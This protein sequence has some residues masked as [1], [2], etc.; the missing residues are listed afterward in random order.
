MGQLLPLSA[1]VTGKLQTA[2]G[3]YKSEKKLFKNRK[4]CIKIKNEIIG[5]RR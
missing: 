4:I 1:T 5:N 2:C 3:H